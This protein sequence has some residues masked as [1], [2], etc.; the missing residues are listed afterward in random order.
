MH[1]PPVNSDIDDAAIDK[2][3]DSEQG[4]TG[5]VFELALAHNVHLVDAIDDIEQQRDG[6]RRIQEGVMEIRELFDDMAMLVD[7]QQETLDNIEHNVVNA[8]QFTQKAE[9]MV[10]KAESNQRSARKVPKHIAFSRSYPQ[11]SPMTCFFLHTEAM[12]DIWRL[13]FHSD[14]YYH[15]VKTLVLA[16]IHFLVECVV[17]MFQ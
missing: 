13:R 1:P 9:E 5:G 10:Q 14:P 15:Y 16:A 4:S 6:M 17:I 8:T 12:D 2:L 7:I 11:H 3:L